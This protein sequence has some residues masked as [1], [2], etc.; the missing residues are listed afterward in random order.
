MMDRLPLEQ[1]DWGRLVL[2]LF[3]RRHLLLMLAGG[4]LIAFVASGFTFGFGVGTSALVAIG[5]IGVACFALFR[6]WF[7][8]VLS[9]LRL[10][11]D[12]DR[13]L[14]SCPTEIGK[15]ADGRI[16]E[17]KAWW[18]ALRVQNRLGWRPAQRCRVMLVDIHTVLPDG[19]PV[20]RGMTIACPL[21]WAVL[22]Q[23]PPTGPIQVTVGSVPEAVNLL[24]LGIVLSEEKAIQ[25]GDRSLIPRSPDGPR[26]GLH[27]T[28]ANWT[29][30][31]RTT[32]R[33]KETARVELQI[34]ADG[35]S[36]ERN[37]V[38]DV[39]WDGKWPDTEAEF[40][41]HVQVRES[42]RTLTQ[43]TGRV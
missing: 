18:V 36:P 3:G 4:S 20:R 16:F 30:N 9:P 27:L 13:Q 1:R 17:E 10:H 22:D 28:L 38:Y 7:Q 29:Y 23:P 15:Y 11:L 12:L 2:S 25:M 40:W 14:L 19:P 32:I 43:P 42:H 37:Y 5:T 31:F 8:R 21:Q 41:Q 6:E 24:R 34:R 35:F 39:Y 26:H 33:P